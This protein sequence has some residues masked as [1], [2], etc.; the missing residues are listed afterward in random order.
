MIAQGQFDDRDRQFIPGKVYTCSHCS[1][2][3][4]AR[5]K[6]GIPKSCP[7]CRSTV[8]MKE[9]YVC[10]CVKCKH[11]WETSSQRPKRCPKCHSTKWDV[12]IAE[13]KANC[14]VSRNTGPR[15]DDGMKKEIVRRYSAG[16]GCISISIG[17]G[18]AFG[19]I[20]SVLRQKYP[21]GHISV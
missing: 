21:D 17:T 13:R 16:E 11:T 5:K 7:R 2:T 15:M 12:P 14:G 9:C 4:V 1:Y 20:F 10:N 8:W 19:M 6:D 18:I 3:W